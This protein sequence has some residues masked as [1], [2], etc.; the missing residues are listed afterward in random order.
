LCCCTTRR[1]RYWVHWIP[2]T[3]AFACVVLVAVE[4][5]G[6][7][8]DQGLAR[9]LAASVASASPHRKDDILSGCAALAC[10]VGTFCPVKLVQRDMT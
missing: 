7:K 10:N 1:P 5:E 8:R 2:T 6:R 9:L 3:I 4:G